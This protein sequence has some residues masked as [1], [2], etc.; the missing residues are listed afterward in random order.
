MENNPR[1][2]A[3][4]FFSFRPLP[5]FCLVYLREQLIKP[6]SR[7][8]ALLVVRLPSIKSINICT[9]TKCHGRAGVGEATAGSVLRAPCGEGAP[10]AP[11]RPI[12]PFRANSAPPGVR[13]RPPSTLRLGGHR[14]QGVGTRSPA[15]PGSRGRSFAPAPPTRLTIRYSPRAV[16]TQCGRSVARLSLQEKSPIT[17]LALVASAR[18]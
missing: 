2:P 17:T 14:G 8:K 1:G 12:R 10:Q 9:G 11:A 18:R 16:A 13:A 7:G 4:G 5:L 3:K 6:Q 15:P